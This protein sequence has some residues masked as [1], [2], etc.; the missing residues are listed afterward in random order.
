MSTKRNDL[1]LYARVEHLL[2]IG[3]S[4][5]FLHDSY[6]QTLEAYDVKTVLDIGCGRGGL[7]EQLAFDKIEAKGID[8][9][10]VMVEDAIA[11]GLNA[12]CIDVADEKGEYDA[13]VA[14]FDVLNFMNA[15]ELDTFLDNVAK[16]LKPGGLLFADINTQYGFSVVAEGTMNAEDDKGFL[17]VDAVYDE[18]EL[19]TI[20]TYFEKG[21]EESYT[22][23][24]QTITQHF[25]PLSFFRRNRGLKLIKHE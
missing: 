14:V 6:A 23:E 3:E 21:E 12:E 7:M 4:T 2:G 15:D 22:K 19:R 17:S 11:K 9:S 16:V 8:L 13:A 25:H 5:Q 18:G 10:E 1:E 24:Q 20:F